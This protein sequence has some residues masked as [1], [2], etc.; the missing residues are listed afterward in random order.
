MPTVIDKSGTTMGGKYTSTNNPKKGRAEKR[1]TK[2]PD[3]MNDAS[4]AD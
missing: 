2:N 3:S 1:K 4:T